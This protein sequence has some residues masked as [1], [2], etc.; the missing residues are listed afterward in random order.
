MA[1]ALAIILAI[2][3]S[4][5]VANDWGK[6]GDFKLAVKTEPNSIW[7]FSKSEW[8]KQHFFEKSVRGYE[9]KLAKL[10]S[11][12]EGKTRRDQL[13]SLIASVEAPHR[14][15][16]AVHYKAKVKPPALP[17]TLTIGQILRWIEDTPGQFHAIGRYQIIPDTLAYLIEAES[18]SPGAVFDKR[19]QDQ[20]AIRLLMDAGLGKFEA[21]TLSI[22]QFMDRVAGVWAGL[23][24]QNDKSAYDG[25]AGNRAIINRDQYKAAMSAIYG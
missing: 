10:P 4:P 2:G 24:L 11:R 13:L 7:N 19:L 20:L 9:F 1:F 3:I 17:S 22:E 25:I 6:D 16:D 14:Q 5:S 15:Y 8:E 23:P 12:Y 18:I 21:G